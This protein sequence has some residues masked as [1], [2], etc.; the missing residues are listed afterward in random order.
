MKMRNIIRCFAALLM[1]VCIFATAMAGITD[2][3][4][5]HDHVGD[6]APRYR[7]HKENNQTHTL[8]KEIPVVCLDCGA[9]MGQFS[10][11]EAKCGVPHTMIPVNNAPKQLRTRN[12]HDASSH[13]DVYQQ[14]T[15]RCTLRE[16]GHAVYRLTKENVRPHSF[17]K[18]SEK[19]D[20]NGK[21]TITY[22]CVCGQSKVVTK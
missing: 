20:K 13:W 2:C 10:Y 16:C 7:G 3:D 4:C 18:E 5:Q 15:S 22:R 17:R 14:M 6:G 1:L 8:V 12:A 19:K 9:D 11:S 21:I